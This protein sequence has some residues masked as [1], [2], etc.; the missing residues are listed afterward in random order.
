MSWTDARLYCQKNHIDL[1]TWTT[2]EMAQWMTE[3]KAGQAWIGL[4][5]DPESEGVWKWINVKT[6]EGI[7]GA[8]VSYSSDWAVGE[9]SHH[10]AYVAD[11][12]KWYSAKCSSLHGFY[13]LK[14]GNNDK[15]T[16][17]SIALDWNTASQQCKL[18]TIDQTNSHEL[19]QTGWIG[20]YR[21]AGESWS[22]IQTSSD[23]R[24]WAPGQPLNAD[25]ASFDSV[26]QKIHS[27]VCS[28]KLSP[29]CYEDNLVVVNENKTWEAAYSHC[30]N[31]NIICSHPSKLCR[32]KHTLLSLV[33]SSDYTYIRDRISR[34]T[35]D[36]VWTG[37]RFLGGEWWWVNGNKPTDHGVLPKCPSQWKHC[38][39]LS[40]HGSNTWSTRDCSEKR[41]FICQRSTIYFV[42]GNQTDDDDTDE[43][44][45]V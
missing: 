2:V 13:C 41:N 44:D 24:N 36:E 31:L 19:S 43:K 33:D 32:Y 37:L 4:L 22:W 7:T 23:Y 45:M 25:C 14:G 40:K 15:I 35:T 16:Y 6:G 9:P 26:T 3:I 27:N 29:I 42:E 30:K 12:M 17:H 21:V 34:A 5:R 8:D 38:G 20:L 10:C 18:P 11:E 28:E 39:T 1:V